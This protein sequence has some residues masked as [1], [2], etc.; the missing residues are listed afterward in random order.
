[1]RSEQSGVTASRGLALGRARIRA[2]RIIDTEER[3]QPSDAVEN[4]VGRLQDAIC[5][6]RTELARLRDRVQGALAQLGQILTHHFQFFDTGDH[7]PVRPA[8]WIARRTVGRNGSSRLGHEVTDSDQSPSFSRF[9]R[10]EQLE[11]AAKTRGVACELD[12]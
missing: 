11:K 1:M 4:E 8:P 6:A 2:P 10:G 5:A 3:S 7:R 9:A 12:E